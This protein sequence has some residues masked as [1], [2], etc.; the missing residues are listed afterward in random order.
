Y[1]PSIHRRHRNLRKL[2]AVDAA[3]IYGDHFATVRAVAAR[4]HVDAAIGAE[5]VADSV[6]VEE[7]FLQI[8]GAGTQLEALRWEIGAVLPL[9]GGDRPVAG[10]PHR[11]TGGA[12][13]PHLAAWPAAG[14]GLARGHRQ[15]LFV[16]A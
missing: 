15:S 12:F 1:A 3:H 7:I 2:D 13:E 11:E 9:V 10:A 14:I 16:S 6:L 8:L 4:E 5:L